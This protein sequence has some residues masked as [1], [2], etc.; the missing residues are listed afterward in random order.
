MHLGVVRWGTRATASWG[1]LMW[2]AASTKSRL[3]R[4]MTPAAVTS[5]MSSTYVAPNR[6]KETIPYDSSRSRG[7]G[8]TIW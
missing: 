6:L 4:P 2:V 5:R 7:Q 1:W 3:V 8:S